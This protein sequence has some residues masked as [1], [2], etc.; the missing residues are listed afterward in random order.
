MSYVFE[1]LLSDYSFFYI[2]K[3]IFPF[4]FFF[5]S[6]RCFNVFAVIF[7]E[8]I[9]KRLQCICVSKVCVVIY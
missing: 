2:D 4:D 8:A 1:K 7:C 6:L 5:F 3:Y 9:Q